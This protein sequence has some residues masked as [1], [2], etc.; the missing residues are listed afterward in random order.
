MSDR[1]QESKVFRYIYNYR[2]RERKSLHQEQR[3]STFRLVSTEPTLHAR[4]GDGMGR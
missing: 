3:K 1:T 4:R 2:R